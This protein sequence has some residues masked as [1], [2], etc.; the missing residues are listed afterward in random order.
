MGTPVGA[1]AICSGKAGTAENKGALGV[2]T[3]PDK[4]KAP[5]TGLGY[6]RVRHTHPYMTL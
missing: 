1:L 6:I 2:I 4:H 3:E 5:C